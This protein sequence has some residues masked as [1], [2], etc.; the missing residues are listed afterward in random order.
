MCSGIGEGF[1]LSVMGTGFIRGLGGNSEVQFSGVLK[2]TT[3]VSARELRAQIS[4]ADIAN[5]GICVVVAC[6]PRPDG[7][8]SC[9]NPVG[10]TVRA[11]P[12][13]PDG[14]SPPSGPAGTLVT[15]SGLS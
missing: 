10:F 7:S 8:S 14:F 9:S 13:R 12:P 4:A 15:I 3:F 11:V 2:P 6:N 1:E 5:P